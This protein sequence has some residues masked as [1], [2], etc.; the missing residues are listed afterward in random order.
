MKLSFGMAITAQQTNSSQFFITHVATPLVRW[1]T[2]H[3]WA[4]S[5]RRNERGELNRTKRYISQS[6]NH[7]EGRATKSLMLPKHFMIISQVESE[8]QG[9]ASC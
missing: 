9:K 7:K 6:Y 2:Y 5:R 8:K 3:F 1:K 4:C